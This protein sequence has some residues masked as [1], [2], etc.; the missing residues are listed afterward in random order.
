VTAPRVPLPDPGRVYGRGLAFPVRVGDDGRLAWS[1]GPA[2]VREGIELVLLTEPGERLELPAFGARLRGFLFAPN[3]V[4]TR[5]LVQEEI[6]RA[7]REW[8]PRVA[9]QSVTVDADDADPRAA[10]ATV[11]YELV[12]TRAPGQASVRVSLG[13]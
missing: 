5:R 2:N 8:E 11:R 10:V 13:G 3:T 9:V 6:V 7:L 12:A 1:A 4:A